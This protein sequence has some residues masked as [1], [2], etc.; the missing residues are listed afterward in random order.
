MLTKNEVWLF[1]SMTM[2][3]LICFHAGAFASLNNK[4]VLF[5]PLD[6]RFTTR[7]AF[8]NLARVTPFNILTPD[9][10]LLPSLKQPAPLTEL[11]QWVDENVAN[12]DAAIVS[13]EMF[14]YGGLIA[15]RQGSV[16]RTL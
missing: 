15:S 7:D 9:R 3:S 2:A 1:S 5:L 8:L 12:C 4:T 6:E 13:S 11:H 14:L 16:L 10:S